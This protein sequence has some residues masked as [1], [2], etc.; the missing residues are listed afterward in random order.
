MYGHTW[1]KTRGHL[2]WLTLGPCVNNKDSTTIQNTCTFTYENKNTHV[3][4]PIA[5]ACV[6]AHFTHTYT[7]ILT[8]RVPNH[9]KCVCHTRRA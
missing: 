1:Y 4:F 7:Q 6:P 9:L 5:S 2:G 3:Q 8:L